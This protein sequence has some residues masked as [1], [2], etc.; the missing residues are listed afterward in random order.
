M[1]RPLYT[2]PRGYSLLPSLPVRQK[3][4]DTGTPMTAKRCPGVWGSPVEVYSLAPARYP[5][6]HLD[7]V[8][9]QSWWLERLVM[10]TPNLVTRV[11]TRPP[12][13]PAT[14]T[15][16]VLLPL[17]LAP[18][19]R[20]RSWKSAPSRRASTV[21]LAAQLEAGGKLSARTTSPSTIASTTSPSEGAVQ[22]DQKVRGNSIRRKVT[23]CN[24]WPIPP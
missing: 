20:T 5:N 8:H 16:C 2:R 10:I 21:C 17:L 6:P 11:P 18:P 13:P 4:M 1:A 22:F 24:A 14:L 19:F 3:C 23:K 15:L 12:P 9:S 7:V